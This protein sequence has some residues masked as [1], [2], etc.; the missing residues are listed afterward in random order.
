MLGIA[1]LF[2]DEEGSGGEDQVESTSR[3]KT[4]RNV[5]LRV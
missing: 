4:T 1:E 3:P 2:A 5:R